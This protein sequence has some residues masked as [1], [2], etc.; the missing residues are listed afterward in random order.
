MIIHN[1]K[2][3]ENLK[4]FSFATISV[5]MRQYINKKVKSKKK[6]NVYI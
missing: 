2:Q 5:V 3:P 6:I 1:T 4:H